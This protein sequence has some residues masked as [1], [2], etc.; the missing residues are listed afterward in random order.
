LEWVALRHPK[1]AKMNRS[2]AIILPLILVALGLTGCQKENQV[3]QRPEK[4]VSLREVIYDMGTYA[5]LDSLWEKYNDAYPS[6]EAYAN[7]MYAARYAGAANYSS[8]LE[9]GCKL[10]PGNPKLLY[11]K[12]LLHHGQPQNLEAL[13]LLERAVELDPSYTDPWFALVIHYLERGE[14][15]K[16]NVALRKILEAGVIADEVMDFSYNML[17]GME[18]DAI[19]VTNGD[20]DT[21]PGWILTQIVGYRPDVHLVNVSLLNTDWYPHTL[22][23]EGIPNLATSKSLDSLKEV[24]AQ[25]L[26]ERKG[27]LVPSGPFS[28][29]LVGRLVSA[30][31]NAGRP[32]YFAPT[33]QH[34]D[35]VKRLLASGRE[36][37]LVTLVTPPAESDAS[38][39]RKILGVWLQDFR[40][41]GLDGWGLLYAKPTRAGKLLVQNY[42]AALHSQMDRVVKLAPD[43][44][45]GLFR[46]YRDHLASH[47][48]DSHREDFNR[49]WCRSDDIKE[50]RDWCRS[51]NLSK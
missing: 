49:M 44:R 17:A 26:K 46:W 16:M 47:I 22:E 12:A 21:Y 23:T 5:R 42:G 41:S 15:E 51:M 8:L 7:W 30:C 9:A 38:Q 25:S 1:E 19:L 36:L 37:G 4:I 14:Q 33:V 2:R 35:S 39:M 32:V 3:V 40:T 28:E 24:F 45:L 50:I 13:S 48:S 6:E 10:Y 20:N 31:R 34:T 18:K 29:L 11:L 43:A 27:P